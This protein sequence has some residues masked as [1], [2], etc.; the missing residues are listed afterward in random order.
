MAAVVV[1]RNASHEGGSVSLP[2]PDRREGRRAGANEDKIENQKKP[3][4]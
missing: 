3:H 4:G 2:A 1:T